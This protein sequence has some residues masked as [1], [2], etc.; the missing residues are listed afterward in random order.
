VTLRGAAP[1][2]AALGAVAV[3]LAAYLG[4]GGASY[5]PTPIADPCETRAWRSPDG[6]DEA[7]EQIAL[8]GLDG[9]ACELGVSREELV[10]ALRDDEALAVFAESRGLERDDAERAVSEALG[11]AVDDAVEADV[12]PGLLAGVV[13]GTVGRIPPWLLIEALERLGGAL[14]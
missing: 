3:V 11:R 14:R 4:L 8:S 2:L 7:I 10:L 13:K 1:L 6:V 12:L 9:A 5:D